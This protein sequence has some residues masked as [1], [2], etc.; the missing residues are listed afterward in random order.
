[1]LLCCFNKAIFNIENAAAHTPLCTS[2]F[3]AYSMW[4]M[5]FSVKGM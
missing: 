3:V 5:Q 1:M 4:A 2:L